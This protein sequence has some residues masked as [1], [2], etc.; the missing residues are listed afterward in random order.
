[1]VVAIA[2]GMPEVAAA[3]PTAMVPASA[4][5]GGHDEIDLALEVIDFEKATWT[6]RVTQGGPPGGDGILLA[7]KAASDLGVGV[8]DTVDVRHPRREGE[9]HTMVTTKMRVSGLHAIPARGFAYLDRS[10]ADLLGLSG[11]VNRV[12]VLPA[13]GYAT[14][15]VQRALRNQPIVVSAVPVGEATDAFDES[16]RQFGGILRALQ[17]IVLGLALLVAFNSASIAADERARE[18]ATMFAYGVQ[19]RSVLAMSMAESAVIGLLSTLVGAFAGYMVLRWMLG[20]LL[21]RT[22]PEIGIPAYLSPSTIVTIVGLGVVVVALA[23]LFTVRKLR[24]VDI[25]ATLRVVE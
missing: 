21:A 23:P 18:N 3:S 4:T 19:V 9:G 12:Q 7:A 14:I 1:Q 10:Q 5:A 13:T 15:D 17:A 2:A 6:P 22:L 20:S 8:G 24:R 25:P 16:L 11:L